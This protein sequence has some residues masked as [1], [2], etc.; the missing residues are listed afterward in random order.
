MELYAVTLK[1]LP[2]IFLMCYYLPDHS[3]KASTNKLGNSYEDKKQ[4]SN[5]GCKYSWGTKDIT[6]KLYPISGLT[7]AN[8]S[9]DHFKD[10]Y[11]MTINWI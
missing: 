2:N 6:L 5:P 10:G 9:I 4:C 1:K 3:T 11:K 7:F 8:I